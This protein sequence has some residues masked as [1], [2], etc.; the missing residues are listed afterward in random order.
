MQDRAGADRAVEVEPRGVEGLAAGLR[1]RLDRDLDVRGVELALGGERDDD[2]PDVGAGREPVGRVG[3][4]GALER[5]V[6]PRGGRY[7]RNRWT[8]GSRL[9]SAAAW[10]AVSSRA[11][12][13]DGAESAERSVDVVRAASSSVLTRDGIS[14]GSSGRRHEASHHAGATALPPR[15][16]SIPP[17]RHDPCVRYVLLSRSFRASA[18][19]IAATTP[20]VSSHFSVDPH[21]R[22]AGARAG[23]S[24]TSTTASPAAARA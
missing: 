6:R 4:A 9:G 1:E 23:C 24:P 14:P 22:P 17:L 16:P 18:S 11:A 13:L 3:L 5:D 21:A 8:R 19:S 10:C 20:S 7:C 2:A 12:P 15:R